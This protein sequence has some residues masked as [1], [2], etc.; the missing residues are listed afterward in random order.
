MPRRAATCRA[1]RKSSSEQQPLPVA[2]PQRRMEMPT[3]SK[4]ASTSS[5]A[6][7]E[8]TTP[9][10]MPMTTRSPRPGSCI[11]ALLAARP[12]ATLHRG[13][14]AA[15]DV[16]GSLSSA[17]QRQQHMRRLSR[18]GGTRGAARHRHTGEIERRDQCLATDAVD[19]NV[20]RVGQTAL[21]RWTVASDARN[22][23]LQ[24]RPQ[25]I[26]QCH[27][28]F[29][30]PTELG[31]RQ[32]ARVPH[33]DD[34]GNVLRPRTPPAFLTTAGEQRAPRKIPPNEQRSNAL[35]TS[36]LMRRQGQHVDAAHVHRKLAGRLHGVDMQRHLTGAADGSDLVDRLDRS[37]LVVGPANAH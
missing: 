3:T 16:T 27:A 10:L 6:A 23:L 12:P 7:T 5:A 37:D 19:A 29:P 18:T 22:A 21:A 14:R 8:L 34:P 20:E 35:G 24:G 2:P 13:S 26:A 31:S 1:S 32:T 33:P 36:E 25:S 28:C 30:E 17:T 15:H 9:P 11:A 4:P